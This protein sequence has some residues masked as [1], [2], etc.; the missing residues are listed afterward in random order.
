MIWA[1][2]GAVVAA[3]ACGRS[4]SVTNPDAAAIEDAAV[5]DS[6]APMAMLD[7]GAET[8]GPDSATETPTP[9]SGAP[10][11]DAP[12]TS[13]VAGCAEA[14][15]RVLASR[16]DGFTYA[17]TPPAGAPIKGTVTSDIGES[18]LNLAYEEPLSVL[19]PDVDSLD[20]TLFIQEPLDPTCDPCAPAFQVRLLVRNL[21][22]TSSATAIAL[23]DANAQLALIPIGTP[24]PSCA[25]AAGKTWLP[26]ALTKVT[27]ILSLGHLASLC[28]PEIRGTLTCTLDA[29]GTFQISGVGPEGE[30]LDITSGTFRAADQRACR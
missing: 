20:K 22:P 4:A 9:D 29:E 1:T 3:G 13:D 10:V 8:S 2:L 11:I 15:A 18:Y 27:G 25:A 12:V 6:D 30:R 26:V 19:W 7:S 23:T 17:F 21:V 16:A 28:T 5:A 24:A 14:N